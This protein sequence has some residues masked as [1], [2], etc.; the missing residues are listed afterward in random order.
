MSRLPPVPGAPASAAFVSFDATD[1]TGPSPCGALGAP[2]TSG[3]A[4][5]TAVG[6]CCD[7]LDAPLDNN[8][9]GLSGI[10][11]R[12]DW[13]ESCDCPAGRDRPPV[14]ASNGPREEGR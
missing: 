14:N 1:E 5:C 7:N 4:V 12:T 2:F 3:T 13:G 10:G 8:D 11:A 6:S 9:K